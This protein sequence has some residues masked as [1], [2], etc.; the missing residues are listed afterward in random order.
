MVELTQF[1]P[2][3]KFLKSISIVG[4]SYINFSSDNLRIA[5]AIAGSQKYLIAD[6]LTI[7]LVL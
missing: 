5:T 6:F 4:I 3:T 2:L 1:L 7:A